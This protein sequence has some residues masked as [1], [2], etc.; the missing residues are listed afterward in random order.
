M[1]LKAHLIDL[2]E[3]NLPSQE[4]FLVDIILKGNAQQRKVII[5]LDGDNGVSISDCAGVSRAMAAALEEDDPFPGQYT[6]EVSS[7]GLDYPLSLKRQYD[8]RMGKLLALKLTG[9]E[10]LNGKLLEVADDEI[11][12]DKVIKIKKRNSTEV[13]KVSFSQIEKAMVQVS[14]K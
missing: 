3:N 9:G 14:F 7:A 6:L 8:S 10:E 13:T 1:E 11:T 5:L 4:H 2:V 12:I